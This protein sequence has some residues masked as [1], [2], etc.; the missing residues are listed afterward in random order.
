MKNFDVPTF[1]EIDDMAEGVYAA[2]G[3]SDPSLPSYDEEIPV[4]PVPNWEVYW[5]HHNG[6]QKSFMRIR[7]NQHPQ[8][9]ERITVVLEL[10]SSANITNLIHEGDVRIDSWD[11]KTIKFTRNNHYN[12]TDYIDI[13]IGAFSF[14]GSPYNIQET[15]SYYDTSCATPHEREVMGNAGP[16]IIRSVDYS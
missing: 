6:G 10:I 12:S 7:G 8:S 4:I 15:G 16:F 11:K 14:E 2:S 3:S 13:N 9:G 1:V 5:D